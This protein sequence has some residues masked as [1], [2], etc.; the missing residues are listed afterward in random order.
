MA[1][2]VFKL[3]SKL[4]FRVNR[5]AYLMSEAVAERFA[6]HGYAITAQDFGILYRLSESGGGLSQVEIAR[7]MNRDKTTITRRLDGLATKGMIERRVCAEDRRV[8]R[9]R[10]TETGQGCVQ[11]LCGVVNAFHDEVLANVDEEALQTTLQTLQKLIGN[12][13]GEAQ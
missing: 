4:G 6:M 10:L 12:I 8:F 2:E 7:L 13:Q 11:A 5:L 1:N 3:E 9:I